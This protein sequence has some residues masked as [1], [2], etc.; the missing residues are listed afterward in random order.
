MKAINVIN[1]QSIFDIALLAYGN[2]E[3][4]VS[5]C[6]E[7]NLSLTDELVPGQTIKV[8]E[9]AES[10]TEIVKYFEDRNIN[11]AT[12]ITTEQQTEVVPDESCNYCKL[13][14]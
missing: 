13:F 6:L 12:A 14:E 11:P 10:K 3:G 2:L 1:Y 5:L 8:P 4:V 9:Y 7:N